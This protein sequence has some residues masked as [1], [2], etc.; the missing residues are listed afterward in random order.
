MSRVGRMTAV[1][2]GGGEK[3]TLVHMLKEC[4]FWSAVARCQHYT[5]NK[6]H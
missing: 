6:T 3:G 4:E 5:R 1:G 2:D